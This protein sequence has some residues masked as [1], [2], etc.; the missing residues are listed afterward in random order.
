MLFS[1]AEQSQTW[2]PEVYLAFGAMLLSFA[3]LWIGFK[4]ANQEIQ[5]T[6]DNANRQIETMINNSEREFAATVLSGNRQQWINSL[7]DEVSEHSAALMVLA[8]HL[9]MLRDNSIPE[10]EKPSYAE[11]MKTFEKTIRLNT[12]IQLLINPNEED[13]A[14]L[15]ELINKA[16]IELGKVMNSNA[17]IADSVVDK[18]VET[19]R[20]MIIAKSQ[21]ILKRE[22]NRVK[23][24]T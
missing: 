10:N 9:L 21:L 19:Y 11:Y 12:K 2:G 6:M 14:E 7:R 3:S 23:D 13:H 15:S 8:N 18:T 1:A 24:G 4:K 17:D 16:T 22:W 5:A 20:P